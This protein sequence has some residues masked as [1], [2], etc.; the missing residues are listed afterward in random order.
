MIPSW[1]QTHVVGWASL[2]VRLFNVHI[3][4]LSI[5]EHHI[6]RTMSQQGL[7]GKHITTRTQIGDGK[8]VPEFVRAG[9]LNFC[10]GTQ[11]VDQDTQTI[12]VERSVGLADEQGGTGIIPVLASNQITPDGFSG[13][14]TQVDCASFATFCSAN[15]SVPNRDLSSLEVDIVYCQ[16]TKFGCTQ[17]GIQKHQNNRLIAIGTRSPHDKFFSLLGL[18][19]P[20]KDTCLQNLFNVFFGKSFNGMRLKFRSSDFY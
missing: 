13:D 15:N 3:R 16:R 2:A 17:S 19:F 20:R 11:P 1:L 6:K 7:K 18:R 12:L 10:S 5:M 9:L 4:N 14:F 8:S